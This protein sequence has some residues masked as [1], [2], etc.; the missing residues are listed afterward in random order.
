MVRPLV[1]IGVNDHGT[2]KKIP[3]EVTF[4]H[5]SPSG[6]KSAG[7]GGPALP[8]RVP[9]PGE[10]VKVGRTVETK[11]DVPAFLGLH[12]LVSFACALGESALPFM[13]LGGARRPSPTSSLQKS[14]FNIHQSTILPLSRRWRQVGGARRP[15]P[16][17]FFEYWWARRPPSLSYGCASRSMERNVCLLSIHSVCRMTALVLDH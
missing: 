2:R 1:A 9:P 7:P 17:G 11:R 8:G 6:P 13:G 5:T 4:H 16:T 14:K 15:S 12:V 3:K 10:P